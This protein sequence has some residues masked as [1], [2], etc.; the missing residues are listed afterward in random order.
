MITPTKMKNSLIKRIFDVVCSF[1]CLIIFSIPIIL[2]IIVL[3]F[4]QGSPIFFKQLR[5][6]LHEKPFE[7]IKF[8]TMTQD[9][10]QF[11]AENMQK[12]DDQ[13][14]TKIGKILR[15]T[16]LDELPSLINVL[17]G[18]MSIV[19]PR[20]LLMHYLKLYSKE[21]SK[22]H[23]AKP[24]ITGW[25]Q[26][27]G[28]NSIKWEIK[29]KLDVWYTENQS[30]LLDIKILLLTFKKVFLREGIGSPGESTGQE[31]KGQK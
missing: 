19:G 3:L 2:I 16:S 20:P 28:R 11:I 26:I 10:N 14:L 23:N 17:K 1:A 7:L 13:R 25:A 29:L 24:G 31:F 9:P 18:E 12:S 30:I 5:P 21:Q 8:R 4:T 6:G 22:R 15:A 27:N